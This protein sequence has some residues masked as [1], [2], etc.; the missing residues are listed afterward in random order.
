MWGC[1]QFRPYL[2]GSH[3][4]VRT[5]H[6]ALKWLKIFKE[7]EG[8]VARWLQVLSEYNFQVNHR[9]GKH[10]NADALSRNICQQCG[11]EEQEAGVSHYTSVSTVNTP[12]QA[13][14][15][16]SFKL[17]QQ[18][19]SNLQQMT[20]WLN[21]N[22]LPLSFPKCASTDL[23]ALWN[24]RHSLKVINGVLYRQWKDIPNGGVNAKLQLV[25]PQHLASDVMSQLHDSPTGGHL[26]VAKTLE[27]VRSRFY[28]IKQRHTVEEWC[29]K[30]ELCCSRKSPP[31]KRCAPMEP[32]QTKRPLEC[33]TMGPLPTTV[34][35]SNC[36][37]IL[38]EVDRSI[39]N[40]RFR[41][42]HSGQ[43]SSQ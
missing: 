38:H 5:D 9:P 42:D 14:D 19:D 39:S 26:G 40:S 6:N 1:R 31:K 23:Q 34:R 4:T 24:Q 7:P 11:K 3:F 43:N 29:R 2:Y 27:K 35:G 41:S 21:D 28:W 25:L 15:T 18:A 10:L 22:T 12:K 33:I 32:F 8:Q 16:H 37:G 17:Q 36:W 20:K 13:W 30:C